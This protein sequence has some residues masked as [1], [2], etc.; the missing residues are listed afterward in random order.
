M[1][2]FST[3]NLRLLS[4][5][6]EQNIATKT[7]GIIL[8]DFTIITT[9]KLVILIAMILD[10]PDIVTKIAQGSIFLLGSEVYY[11]DVS[12]LFIKYPNIHAIPA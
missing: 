9:G 5:T 7:T 6:R 8:H 2:I 11:D 3:P 4:L 12:L 10:N 1:T